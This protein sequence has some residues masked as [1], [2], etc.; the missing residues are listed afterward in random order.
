MACS[1]ISQFAA[2]APP[3]RPDDRVGE[4]RVAADPAPMAAASSRPRSSSRRSWSWPEGASCS[5]L[6]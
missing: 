2:P 6:A 4:G 3:S 1:A 5:V